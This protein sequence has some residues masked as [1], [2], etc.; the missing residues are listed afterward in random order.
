MSILNFVHYVYKREQV[1][2]MRLTFTCQEWR[3]A[4]KKMEVGLSRDRPILPYFRS[5]N[6]FSAAA[7]ADAHRRMRLMNRNAASNYRRPGER[8]PC[9]KFTYSA[10][11]AEFV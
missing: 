3:I 11:G 10:G 8:G 7:N 2:V 5:R 1:N 4:G 9:K 6:C